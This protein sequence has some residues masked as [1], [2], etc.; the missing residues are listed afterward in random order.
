[1]S[2]AIRDSSSNHPDSHKQ[3]PSTH[4]ERAFS[5]KRMNS[6]GRLST[7]DQT[8]YSYT[9]LPQTMSKPS[10]KENPFSDSSAQIKI[11]KSSFILGR[12][13]TPSKNSAAIIRNPSNPSLILDKRF[14]FQKETKHVK[15]APSLS[16]FSFTEQKLS[17]G[18]KS[19]KKAQNTT[20]S[21]TLNTTLNNSISQVTECDEDNPRIISQD[22]KYAKV[23]EA[24]LMEQLKILSQ[25][26]QKPSEDLLTN[27][28]EL[29]KYAFGEIIGKNK[30]YSSVLRA[31]KDAYEEAYD[32]I[33]KNNRETIKNLEKDLEDSNLKIQNYQAEIKSLRRKIEK[34]AKESVE[35][36]RTLDDRETQ[37]NEIHE[38]LYTITHSSIENIPKDEEGWKALVSEIQEYSKIVHSMSSEIKKLRHKEKQLI[39]LILALKKRGYPVEEI[40]ENEISRH[41]QPKETKGDELKSEDEYELE[42]LVKG[43]PKKIVRPGHV[44]VLN[45][46]NVR[47]ELSSESED[48][49]SLSEDSV[50]NN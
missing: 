38:R 10:F 44:P 34:L 6:K 23:I 18:L 9:N 7:D 13:S 43:S 28:L 49:D 26:T 11:K 4:K 30:A 20:M 19:N 25:K 24:R 29:Y 22:F 3:T 40:Y 27:K 46:G 1:M 8:K 41:K 47:P 5:R 16:S 31:I 48:I 15:R 36:S 39:N 14:S 12:S 32:I 45:L 35:L 33:T 42:P 50:V 37:Y 2:H 17:G 21:P